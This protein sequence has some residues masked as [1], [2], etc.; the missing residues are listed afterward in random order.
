[1]PVK[2]RENSTSGVDM[3]VLAGSSQYMSVV[4]LRPY[5]DVN[6]D[7]KFFLSPFWYSC[8][9]HFSPPKAAS[10]FAHINR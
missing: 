1:M 4:K 2:R 3:Y 7:V 9:R 5:L 8:S 10:S 6:L